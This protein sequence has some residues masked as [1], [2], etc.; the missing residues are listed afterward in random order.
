[1]PFWAVT[2]AVS[3][4]EADSIQRYGS[5]TSVPC[6][7]STVAPRS[8]KGYRSTPPG[9][10]AELMPAEPEKQKARHQEVREGFA[11][12]N[13]AIATRFRKQLGDWYPAGEAEKV[14]HAEGFELCEYGAQPN[15]AELKRLFPFFD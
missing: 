12:R 2:Q 10:S 5:A 11:R 7:T 8:A 4:V 14:K 13:Q 1:M 15:K 3:V 6:S 9:S